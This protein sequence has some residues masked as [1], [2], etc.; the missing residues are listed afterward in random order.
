MEN[1]DLEA[2]PLDDLWALH[3]QISRF[4]SE[5]MTAEKQQLEVRL[6]RLNRVDKAYG[7]N[8]LTPIS[9]RNGSPR[10]KY[11]KVFPKYQNSKVPFETWSGRG[12]QPRW[13]VSALKAGRKIDDFEIPP[14]ERG[15]PR[16]KAPGQ[17]RPD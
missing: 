10:R 6:Q 9:A 3:E 4:L 15:R 16:I 14:G 2:M 7:S 11:P 1:L 8:G 5:R 13:L 12:R 17:N